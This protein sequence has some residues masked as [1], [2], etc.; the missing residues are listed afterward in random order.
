MRKITL[1]YDEHTATYGAEIKNEMGFFES[2]TTGQKTK[3]KLNEWLNWHD[4]TA[5]EYQAAKVEY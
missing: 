4:V 2:G 1:T 5:E 3:N